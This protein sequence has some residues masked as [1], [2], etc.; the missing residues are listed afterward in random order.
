MAEI[1]VLKF[2]VASIIWTIAWL[3]WF[4]HTVAPANKK[5]L[6]IAL[7]PW[8]IMLIYFFIFWWG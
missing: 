1:L 7:A 2:I 6:T 4:V 8:Y 5:N 3:G